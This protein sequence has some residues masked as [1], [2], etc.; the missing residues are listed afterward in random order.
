MITAAADSTDR[1]DRW[2]W[3]VRLFKTRALATAACRAGGVA[4]N[5]R[6][7]KPARNVRAGETIT[8]RQGLITRTLLVRGLPP[9]RLGARLVPGFCE[10][11]TPAGEFEKARVQRLQRVIGREK[12]SGRPTKRERRE[13]DRLFE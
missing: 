8:L 11:L 10:D 12:G 1:L 9:S 7:A 3:T 4:V 5:D 13:R 6:P 2:L